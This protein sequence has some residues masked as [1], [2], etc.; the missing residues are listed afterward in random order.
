LVTAGDHMVIPGSTSPE[1]RSI[2]SPWELPF[3]SLQKPKKFG[4][5]PLTKP[6]IRFPFTAVLALPLLQH[7][8]HQAIAPETGKQNYCTMVSAIG[9]YRMSICTFVV[10]G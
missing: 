7:T 4:G 2:S 9:W 5:T 10:K 8:K 1:R 6:V 3:S